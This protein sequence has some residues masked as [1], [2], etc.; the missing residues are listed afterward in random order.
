MHVLCNAWMP[1]QSRPRWQAGMNR[2]PAAL[3]GHISAQQHSSRHGN[4][5]ETGKSGKWVLRPPLCFLL[6]RRAAKGAQ[7]P[8][9]CRGCLQVL[10]VPR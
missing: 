4:P 3:C 10:W 5:P 2:E 1:P 7:H 6:E 9:G 8:G